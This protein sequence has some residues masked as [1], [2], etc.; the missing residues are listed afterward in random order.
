MC[1]RRGGISGDGSALEL[2]A[3]L[4]LPFVAV[5]G[6]RR[7]GAWVSFLHIFVLSRGCTWKECCYHGCVVRFRFSVVV[8]LRFRM[9]GGT[10]GFF[11]PSII[12]GTKYRQVLF[13]FCLFRLL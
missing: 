4:A 7:F 11:F 10:L 2:V 1:W 3:V 12:P 9:L 13:V 5:V 6:E 8:G